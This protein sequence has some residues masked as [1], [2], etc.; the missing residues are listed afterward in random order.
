MTMV[1]VPGA[2]PVSMQMVMT[3]RRVAAT[4]PAGSDN[5]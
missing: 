1:P 2:D 3:V 4:R 5:D